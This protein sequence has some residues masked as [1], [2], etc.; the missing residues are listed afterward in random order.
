MLLTLLHCN[1]MA[2]TATTG[3]TNS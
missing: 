3:N 1:A 2:N